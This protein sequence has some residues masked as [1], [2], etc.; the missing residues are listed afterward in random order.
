VLAFH[1]NDH[2]FQEFKE[3]LEAPPNKGLYLSSK[4]MKRSLNEDVDPALRFDSGPISGWMTQKRLLN[5]SQAGNIN[6]YPLKTDAE[7]ASPTPRVC[8]FCDAKKACPLFY[9]YTIS[10]ADSEPHVI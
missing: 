4:F 5:A 3:F 7:A 9:R 8:V 1:N 2:R 6:I 10:G